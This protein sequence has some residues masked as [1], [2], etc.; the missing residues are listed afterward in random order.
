MHQLA[1]ETEP[2]VVARE[3]ECFAGWSAWPLF[4]RIQAPT[5]LIAGEHESEHL[6]D[7]A[8]ALPNARIV[9][10]SGLGHLGAF[11]H[12]E[13]VLPHVVPFLHSITPA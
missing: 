12:S 2:E 7:A 9:V 1:D 6:G 5:L 4:G 10:L 13:C 3:L 11:F 8:A